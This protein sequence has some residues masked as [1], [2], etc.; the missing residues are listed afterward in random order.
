MYSSDYL[1]AFHSPKLVNRQLFP[2]PRTMLKV[3]MQKPQREYL[4]NQL[5]ISIISDRREGVYSSEFL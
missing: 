4:E 2:L 5:L 1:L 3:S